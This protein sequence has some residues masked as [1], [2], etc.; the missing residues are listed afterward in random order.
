MRRMQKKLWMNWTIGGSMAVQYMLNF[1]Q[2]LTSEKLVVDSMRWGKICA[3]LGFQWETNRD[4][5]TCIC[6]FNASNHFFGRWIIELLHVQRFIWIWGEEKK[7]VMLWV[8][9]KLDSLFKKVFWNS[10][11]LTR[12]TAVSSVCSWIDSLTFRLFSF[13][14][15]LCT[16]SH[17]ISFL[18]SV[19][20]SECT[21]GGF[22][23]FMHL[24]PISRELRREL[25]GRS[26]RKVRR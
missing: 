15:Q 26:R 21:R 19:Y 25:Y 5:N 24:K 6:I 11:Y 20:Y 22:C 23:N 3:W 14:S 8:F 2:W 10:R 1:H 7:S 17:W 16:G 12:V 18:L 9:L 13:N 4:A